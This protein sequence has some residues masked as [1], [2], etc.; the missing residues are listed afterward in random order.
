MAP[1]KPAATAAS[2][3]EAKKA[4]RKQKTL[5]ATSAATGP[6][7]PATKVTLATPTGGSKATTHNDGSE[8]PPTVGSQTPAL[9]S[10]LVD[11]TRT[12]AEHPQHGGHRSSDDAPFGEGFPNGGQADATERN[13]ALFSGALADAATRGREETPSD[14][15]MDLVHPDPFSLISSADFGE[16]QGNGN[17]EDQ[18]KDASTHDRAPDTADSDDDKAR[19]DKAAEIRAAHREG[20]TDRQTR[21][22]ADRAS[23]TEDATPAITK[24]IAAHDLPAAGGA[25][26]HGIPLYSA[27]DPGRTIE[28]GVRTTVKIDTDDPPREPVT[29]T[30]TPNRTIAQDQNKTPP[31]L[32]PAKR[33]HAQHIPR[34]PGLRKRPDGETET[35]QPPT[36]THPTRTGETIAKS[37]LQTSFAGFQKQHFRELGNP[38]EPSSQRAGD[39]DRLEAAAAAAAAHGAP[40]HSSRVADGRYDVE[41]GDAEAAAD[42]SLS[43]TDGRANKIQ[44]SQINPSMTLN[45]SL[46]QSTGGP[47]DTP[48]GSDS[49][50]TAAA[51]SGSE[52]APIHAPSTDAQVAAGKT[53]HR[54]TAG[55]SHSAPVPPR[56]SHTQPPTDDATLAA[57]RVERVSMSEDISGRLSGAFTD[58]SS[59]L[60]HPCVLLLASMPLRRLRTALVMDDGDVN[61]FVASLLCDAIA[62]T[63]I[64]RTIAQCL[65]HIP[66]MARA[67]ALKWAADAPRLV[68]SCFDQHGNLTH[69]M[70][71]LR[72]RLSDITAD[73]MEYCSAFP[74]QTLVGDAPKTN[75]LT[76]GGILST[77]PSGLPSL[78][79]S[80][81]VSRADG[82][83]EAPMRGLS[84]PVFPRQ[85]PPNSLRP[86]SSMSHTAPSPTPP[87]PS[88]LAQQLLAPVAAAA[89]TLSWQQLAAA[90]VECSHSTQLD[91]TPIDQLSKPTLQ[92]GIF[93]EQMRREIKPNLTRAAILAPFNRAVTRMIQDPP[94][95]TI[96][97][98]WYGEGLQ[99][100]TAMA[101]LLIYSSPTEMQETFGALMKRA[102][103]TPPPRNYGE[104]SVFVIKSSDSPDELCVFCPPVIGETNP[105]VLTIRRGPDRDLLLKFKIEKER[106]RDEMIA[107]QA[108][109]TAATA[110]GDGTPLLPG[111][112]KNGGYVSAV[113]R[114]IR[115]PPLDPTAALLYHVSRCPHRLIYYISPGVFDNPLS[116]LIDPS[117]IQAALNPA[118]VLQCASRRG[119]FSTARDTSLLLQPPFELTPAITPREAMGGTWPEEKGAIG[120]APPVDENTFA[121]PELAWDVRQAR[122][123]TGSTTINALSIRLSNTTLQLTDL[124]FELTSI[125]L[126][127]FRP[128]EVDPDAWFGGRMEPLDYQRAWG[129]TRKIV[130][131]PA[132][133]PDYN[134]AHQSDGPDFDTEERYKSG[135]RWLATLNVLIDPPIERRRPAQ[136][137]RAIRQMT[138]RPQISQQPRDQKDQ[139]QRRNHFST[140]QTHRSTHPQSLGP[141]NCPPGVGRVVSADDVLTGATRGSS[142][143]SSRTG[144][145]NQPQ[146]SSSRNG[147][148]QHERRRDQAP[149]SGG[150]RS[151]GA[152][153][154]ESHHGAPGYQTFDPPVKHE[155]WFKDRSGKV[156]EA[157][158]GGA[159][160]PDQSDQ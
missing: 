134:P 86:P 48:A 25:R 64:L 147:H 136:D 54:P 103:T 154:E 133:G 111:P 104:L 16:A 35:Q 43:Q 71:C 143:P 122:V 139:Q 90:A 51:T 91:T 13:D 67:L 57:E 82:A 33:G 144:S 2:A 123:K 126:G 28:I 31:A 117:S 127:D 50:P 112:A 78:D 155:P 62:E 36:N 116:R 84:P 4:I 153:D 85:P 12:R 115:P 39:P 72:L 97:G 131:Q 120:P 114:N 128:N 60:Y 47:S 109:A 119:A 30:T 44:I 37:N 66:S 9:S 17:K 105:T 20:R 40:S 96:E 146:R 59:P 118:I 18:T 24:P 68:A 137:Q 141:P 41:M 135:D 87:V 138:G 152:T 83:P 23:R 55:G 63:T 149:P 94:S 81:S 100:H 29:G 89:T 73:A 61:N 110:A 70:D 8:A 113:T 106:R 151:R 157:S 6:P 19:A 46:N 10:P 102:H 5:D 108:A 156:R 74:P 101:A 58:A 76:G 14:A 148:D 7:Q 53:K 92:R 56:H 79:P 93:V 99:Q 142:R 52:A 107:S 125:R 49:V 26:G 34:E 65:D 158:W 80:R 11:P 1:K 121:A 160:S 22:T 129:S 159:D 77:T 124:N 150:E 21:L 42:T 88:T 45:V 130:L 75:D 95:H 98:L 145:R 140:T 27:T 38:N 132:A 32:V 69:G 15:A 3:T